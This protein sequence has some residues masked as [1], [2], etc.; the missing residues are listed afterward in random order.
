MELKLE[1]KTSVLFR[2]TN[3]KAVKFSADA[4]SMLDEFLIAS[5]VIQRGL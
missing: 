5:N 1:E 3:C 2:G 4:V